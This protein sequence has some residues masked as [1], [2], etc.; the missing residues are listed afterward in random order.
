MAGIPSQSGGCC[1]PRKN[2]RQASLADAGGLMKTAWI[3]WAAFFAAR[4][5]ASMTALLV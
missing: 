5:T 4:F 3:Y 2:H 1:A